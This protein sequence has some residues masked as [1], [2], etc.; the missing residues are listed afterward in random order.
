MSVVTLVCVLSDIIWRQLQRAR[1]CRLQGMS[2]GCEE[3]MSKNADRGTVLG[4][5]PPHPHT[6]PQP[7]RQWHRQCGGLLT[8]VA[9]PCQAEESPAGGACPSRGG[10]GA[11]HI[12]GI[13]VRIRNELWEW[14]G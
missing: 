2:F 3:G 8:P 11:A 9:M 7:D 4:H 10:R 6:I 12:Q 5:I 1:L 13:R 14:D